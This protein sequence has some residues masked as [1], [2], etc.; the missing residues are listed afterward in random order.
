M[1]GESM[2]RSSSQNHHEEQSG[3][4]SF[5]SGR[6]TL[7]GIQQA[8][9]QTLYTR[10]RKNDDGSLSYDTE[11]SKSQRTAINA[12]MN[13]FELPDIYRDGLGAKKQ[14]DEEESKE[15]MAFELGNES[16]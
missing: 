14:S 15:M 12:M 3:A 9:R 1:L 4:S 2:F 11:L 16:N 5:S 7:S 10:R 13:P 6:D 8:V